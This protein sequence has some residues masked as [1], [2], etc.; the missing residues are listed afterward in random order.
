[1]VITNLSCQNN[2]IHD[3][4]CTRSAAWNPR[5]SSQK[6]T[7]T[8]FIM[9]QINSRS[10]YNFSCYSPHPLLFSDCKSSIVTSGRIESMIDRL[11][12]ACLK[13]CLPIQ[14]HIRK[15][16]FEF[17]IKWM[18]DNTTR[19]AR[20]SR[21]HHLPFEAGNPL[22]SCQTR[23]CIPSFV[24]HSA[25]SSSPARPTNWGTKTSVNH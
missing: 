25:Q 14:T 23:S 3:L 12:L 6:M 5:Y 20:Q 15:A 16:T 1:M 2:Y 8:T 4:T 10:C 19:A 17:A 9:V 24:V 11:P 7:N 21:G 13:G 18:H 22:L